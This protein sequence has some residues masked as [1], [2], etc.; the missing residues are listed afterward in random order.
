MIPFPLFISTGSLQLRFLNC[1]VYFAYRELF[2]LLKIKKKSTTKAEVENLLYLV[3]L[4]RKMSVFS[5]V[6]LVHSHLVTNGGDNFGAE[7]FLPILATD[8]LGAGRIRGKEKQRGEY[9]CVNKKRQDS[10]GDRNFQ[11]ASTECRKRL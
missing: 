7:P 1:Q 8:F 5:S 6:H 9:L 2:F 10:R 3:V 4:S 11:Q